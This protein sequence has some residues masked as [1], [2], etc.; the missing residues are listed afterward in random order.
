[1]TAPDWAP[2][3]A[4]FVETDRLALASALEQVRRRVCEYGSRGDQPCDCKYGLNAE[5]G[6]PEPRWS[7]RTGCPELRVV[8]HELLAA[9]AAHQE[10]S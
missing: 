3:P 9:A 2:M 7:E 4:G 1:M 10:P 8:I 6:M 5:L